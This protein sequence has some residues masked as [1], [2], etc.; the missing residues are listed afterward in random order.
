MTAPNITEDRMIFKVLVIGNDLPLQTGFLSSA[1]GDRISCQLYNTLGLSLGVAKCE[2]PEN[3]SV[4]LQLWSIPFCERM[5]GLSKTL[6][7]GHR[8]IV[9]VLR[10]HEIDFIP[11]IFNRL[12]L[13]RETPLLIV[14]V[15]SVREAEI[16]TSHLDIYLGSHLPV[17]AVQSIEDVIELLAEGL[18]PRGSRRTPFRMIVALANEICPTYEPTISETTLPLN[19]E[20]EIDEIRSIAVELGLRIIGNSCAVELAEGVV[21]VCM[22]TGNIQ[23]EPE[24]CRYCTHGCRRRSNICIVATDAGWSSTNLGSR[25]LLTVAKIYAL[26]ARMLPRHVRKQI[27][28][29]SLCMRFEPNPSIPI[30][31][32]PDEVLKGSKAANSEKPLLEA[33]KQRMKEGKLSRNVFSMLKKKLHNIESSDSH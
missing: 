7:K 9:L 31:E 24:I 10:P 13:S 4:V 18:L 22:R 33:A 28:S 19:S 23:M 32:I 26:S 12:A 2:F 16:G 17:Q 27:E 14:V 25:A 11:E 1:S 15:G 5:I 3:G 20:E 29:I 6:T 8:A 30:E 21:W